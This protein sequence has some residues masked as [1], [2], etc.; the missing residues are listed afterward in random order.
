[1]LRHSNSRAEISVKTV[2]RALAGNTPDNGDLN[3]DSFQRAML[4]YRNTPDPITKISPAIAVFARPIKDLIPVLPSISI[5]TGI[6]YWTTGKQP[7]PPEAR[8]N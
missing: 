4:T 3:C 1:M 6:D 5:H 2:K 8:R 7:W